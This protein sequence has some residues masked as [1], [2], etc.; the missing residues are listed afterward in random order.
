[1]TAAEMLAKGRAAVVVLNGSQWATVT[2]GMSLPVELV[3]EMAAL[4][5]TKTS[6][7][8]YAAD[9]A[10]PFEY[11]RAAYA[12]ELFEEGE[13]AKVML[14]AVSAVRPLSVEELASMGVAGVHGPVS[15]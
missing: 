4:A 14:R 9:P 5:G 11:A 15:P 13:H 1:M 12:I 7:H 2:V 10:S 6:V 3:R 8:L